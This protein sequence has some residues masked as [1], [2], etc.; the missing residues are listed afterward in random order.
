MIDH[1][2]HPTIRT[3]IVQSIGIEAIQN[4][5]I[6]VSLTID[7]EK[8]QTSDHITKDPIIIT[9]KI[10]HEIAPKIRIQTITINNEIIPNLL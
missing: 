1:E 4:I 2:I 9:I 3:G 10:E 7:Q 6:N 8:I 5:K